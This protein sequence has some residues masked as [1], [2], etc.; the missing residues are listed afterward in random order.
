[1]QQPAHAVVAVA[2]QAFGLAQS[3]GSSAHAARAAVQ[4]LDALS[5]PWAPINIDHLSEMREWAARADFHAAPE[6]V[7]RVYADV[8]LGILA[9]VSGRPADV[10]APPA[11]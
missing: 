10:C 1:M 8:W 3:G 6:S 11:G 2:A 9:V 5:R 7:E 4:A